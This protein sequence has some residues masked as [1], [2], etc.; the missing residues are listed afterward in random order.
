[1]VIGSLPKYNA[2]I[3]YYKIEKDYQELWLSN[4]TQHGSAFYR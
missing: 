3:G 4:L 1:M 2:K